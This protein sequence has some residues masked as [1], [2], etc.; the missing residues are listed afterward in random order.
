[1]NMLA[2]EIYQQVQQ[3]PAESAKEVL[4]FVE[5]LKF[6]QQCSETEYVRNN[7]QLMQQIQVA[8]S[9]PDQWFKPSKAQ[10]NLEGNE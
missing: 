10:L 2:E 5:F 6:K 7:P 4:K 9:N 3:L 8:D 1:M